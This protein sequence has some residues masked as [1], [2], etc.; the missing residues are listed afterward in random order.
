MGKRQKSKVNFKNQFQKSKSRDNL[1]TML[2]SNKVKRLY[3]FFFYYLC[4]KKTFPI[5]TY[6]PNQKPRTS[7]VTIS[8]NQCNPWQKNL[9]PCRQAKFK[10]Q[11]QKSISK[12]K[13]QAQPKYYA[14]LQQCKKS[15]SFLTTK[16]LAK[17]AKA[18]KNPRATQGL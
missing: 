3:R 9:A 8:K 10:R 14:L 18:K 16:F 15:V 6:R 12:I 5:S 11:F 4:V 1:S 2:Y 17:I 7:Y 13:R